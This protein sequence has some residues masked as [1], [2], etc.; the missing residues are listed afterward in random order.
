MKTASRVGGAQASVVVHVIEDDESS[1]TAS[2]RVLESAGHEV[3]V[4]TTAAE[5]L[6]HPP[7]EAGCLVLDLRLPGPSG[8]DLQ[9]RLKDLDNPLPIVFLTGHGDIPKTVRAMQ[10]GAS[11]F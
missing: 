3:R 6:A 2:S 9:E 1:R 8:L 5:F 7:S 4:Y 10:A 11:I